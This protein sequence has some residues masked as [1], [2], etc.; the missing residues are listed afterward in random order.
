MSLLDSRALTPDSQLT[1]SLHRATTTID[2]LT[3]ALTSVSRVSSPDPDNVATCCCGR[4]DCET[5]KSWAAFKTKL[6][7]RLVLSAEVGRA[8][9]ERHEA[10]VRRQER[11]LPS[12]SDDDEDDTISF[13]SSVDVRV[14]ELV[15]QNALLEKRLTQALMHTEMGETSKKTLLQEL[16]EARTDV[17]RLSSQNA[18]AV[19]LENRLAVALQEKD[20]LKQELDSATQ[21]TRMTESRIISYRE[22]CAKLQAQ[23]LRLR[24]DLDVQRTHRQELSQEILS[25]AKQRL[26]QLQYHQLGHSADVHDAEVTKV[27]ESLVADNEALKRDNAELQNLL[28]AEREELHSLQEELEE[29]RASDTPFRRG[30]RFTHSGNSFTF[31]DTFSPLSPTFPIGTAPTASLLR[32]RL[33]SENATSQRRSLSAERS[34]ELSI[35]RPFEPLTPETERRPL[36]PDSHIHAGSKWTSFAN[37]RATYAHSHISFDDREGNTVSPERPRAQKPLLLLTRDRG[38]QTD[39]TWN[40]TSA[41]SPSPIPR[42]FG[43]HVSSHDGQSESSSLTDNVHS[44]AIGVIVERATTLLNRMAQA[45]ALTLTNRL[46]RQHLL[47][48]DVGHLS[49]TT[50]TAILN[51]ATALRTHFRAF[52]EDEKMTTTCTRRDLR[53]L[54][55]L[56]KDVFTELGELRVTLNAV[57]LDPTVAGKVS[58]MAMH[59]SK[60]QAMDSAAKDGATGA[61]GHSWMAPLSKLLGLPG[62]GASPSE[63]AAS[64][65]LSPTARNLGRGRPPPRIA[66]KLQPALSASAMTVN[67]EFSGAAVGRAVTSTYS[68]HPG[69]VS[70]FGSLATPG[71]STSATSPPIAQPTPR[72]DLSRSVMGI[73][74]GAPRPAEGD[75]WIVIPRPP[76]SSR[77]LSGTTSTMGLNKASA[78]IGRASLRGATHGKR[79]SRIV[80]AVIDSPQP[81]G[82]E[83]S[84]QGSD[85]NNGPPPALE[86]ALRRGLS[87]SSIRTTFTQHG[88]DPQPDNHAGSAQPA[89]RESVLQALSRKMQAFRFMSA[90]P[91]IAETTASTASGETST[92]RPQ[93]PVS[94]KNTKASEQANT[95]KSSPPRP[96]PKAHGQSE[97]LTTSLFDIS[98]WTAGYPDV[99][100]N[101]PTIP[102]P[103]YASSPR[104]EVY[105]ERSWRRERDI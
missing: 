73:F 98:S 18:R 100:D 60:A 63:S 29:R 1:S 9:L 74:A 52:L 92:S 14:A 105:M 96:I 89:D 49:R 35:R 31:H 64:S 10:L 95:P 97:Q 17:A 71:S 54:L 16:E 85:E 83:T 99:R 50:V 44:S 48:A 53:G 69:R 26:E 78:T 2:E 38:V 11:K 51:D 93:T 58:E 47:G 55:K 27:L 21:R 37:P 90:T 22:K 8:L 77:K 57:I 28:G 40:T 32:S 46:K 41:L 62:G 67:V 102:T 76:S 56:V 91:A 94:R 72:Q 45:D 101:D 5:S 33:Q 104:D 4:E 84:D 68:A 3:H 6:E 43:D 81:G 70:N 23:V 86:R 20:D 79:L 25:D 75:P 7:S 88:E 82:G 61:N 80:D 65:A 39:L 59:P 103:Y 24:E 19:G 66:P 12:E 36:S 13:H 87:D 30:H 15:K 34:R 42:A